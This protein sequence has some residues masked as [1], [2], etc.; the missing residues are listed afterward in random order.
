MSGSF[1]FEK[2]HNP[3]GVQVP[4]TYLVCLVHCDLWPNCIFFASRY[5]L[6]TIRPIQH[7]SMALLLLSCIKRNNFTGSTSERANI[8]NQQFHIAVQRV[9][10]REL[11]KETRC[12]KAFL[13][14]WTGNSNLVFRSEVVSFADKRTTT[15]FKEQW[16]KFSQVVWTYSSKLHLKVR[17]SAPIFNYSISFSFSFRSYFSFDTFRYTLIENLFQFIEHP[18]NTKLRWFCTIQHLLIPE[19]ANPGFVNYVCVRVCSFRR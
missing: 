13:L 18:L 14:D 1:G 16:I 3:F 15:N 12:V 17:N 11:A 2:V 8:Y 7:I 10:D 5:N 9:F 4:V 6:W 19:H